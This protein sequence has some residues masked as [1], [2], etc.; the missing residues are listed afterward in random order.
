MVGSSDECWPW[1]GAL[2]NKGAG[3][4]HFRGRTRAA[5]RVAWE[6]AHGEPCGDQAVVVTCG[7][8]LCC[9]P[10]HMALSLR[11]SGRRTGE[12]ERRF[13][14]RVDKS[15]GPDACWPWTGSRRGGGYGRVTVNGRSTSA[16]R[17]AY[18][19]THGTIPDGKHV[20]HTCDNP[21]CCNPAHL[22]V[23]TPADNTRDMLSK[24]RGRW[25]A[26]L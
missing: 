24:G 7:N 13:W 20:C 3:Q 17:V 9:N 6:L 22:W 14:G 21:P 4:A 19:L 2:N 5:R 10:A 8:H 25:Q 23:G 1:A 26:Y 15:A 11:A 18:E 12:P 16:S